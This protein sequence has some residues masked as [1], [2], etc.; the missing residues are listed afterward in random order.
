MALKSPHK[1]FALIR[2]LKRYEEIDKP[3]SHTSSRVM[4]PQYH[5]AFIKVGSP[6]T[7][8][9]SDGFEFCAC[10]DACVAKAIAPCEGGVSPTRVYSMPPPLG[11]GEAVTL[12]E[13]IKLGKPGCC[14][15][16]D[17]LIVFV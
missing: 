4:S 6:T 9:R 5:S 13:F 16:C 1:C 14:G 8:P 17:I 15:C 10:P 11:D 2:K 3:A 12:I 7:P